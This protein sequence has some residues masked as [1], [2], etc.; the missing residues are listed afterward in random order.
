M[1]TVLDLGLFEYFGVIFPFLFATIVVYAILE[2]TKMLVDDKQA[3]NAMV[4]LI[5][6][7]LLIMSEKAVLLIKFITPWFVLLFIFFFLMMLIFR[8][9]GAK[10]EDFKRAAT[11]EED[12][13]VMYWL[14][15]L[16]VLILVIGL[17]A[18]YGDTLTPYT[19]GADTTTDQFEAN[20]WS[21]FFHPKVIGLIFISLVGAFTIKLL[22]GDIYPIKKKKE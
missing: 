18:V 21:A 13:T 9:F 7:V 4:G 1:A 19:G 8:L 3:I 11:G 20:A 16:S 22:A 17:G 5:A 14:I 2:S 10:D 6:G 12:K 15:T